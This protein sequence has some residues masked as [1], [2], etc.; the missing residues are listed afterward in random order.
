MIDKKNDEE[1]QFMADNFVLFLNIGEA[2]RCSEIEIK[3]E[4]MK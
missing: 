3:N 4:L 2:A 1:A